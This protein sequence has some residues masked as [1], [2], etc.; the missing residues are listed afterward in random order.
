MCSNDV[1]G[2]KTLHLPPEGLYLCLRIKLTYNRLTGE[3]HTDL[4][5]THFTRH[6]N[7]NEEMKTQGNGKLNYFIL[8]YKNGSS[9]GKVAKIRGETKR[10]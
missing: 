2:G 8:G 1:W 9:C 10:S 6:G 4:F 3:N 5:N 7:T